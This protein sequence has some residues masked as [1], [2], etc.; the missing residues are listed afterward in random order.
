MNILLIKPFWPYPYNKTDYTY[1]RIWPPLSLANCAG[2][3]EEE[4]FGVKILDCH[5]LRLKPDRIK[6]F[7]S[8][9]D[10][11][12]ITSSSLDRWQ[13]PN[14]NISYFLETLRYIKESTDE[15]YVMGYH[16]TVE[17]KKILDLTDAK[18]VIRG[19]P[20]YTVLEICKNN[21][22]AEIKGLSFK[23]KGRIVSTSG[24][25]PLDLKSL[26]LPAFH[27]LDFRK[28]FYEILGK[29]FSLFEISRGC[30]F[31]CRF[32]NK[33]M[34]GEDLRTKSRGQIFAEVTEAVEKFNVKTGYFI[35]LDFLS[36]REIA[37]ELCNY[38]I[39][40]KY[41]FKW[42]C[43]ARP[44]LLDIE[45]LKKMKSAGCEIIHL[46]IESSVPRLLFYLNKN[47]AIEKVRHSI[48]LCQKAGMKTLAFFLFGLPGETEEDR[49]RIFSC[50]KELNNDFVSFHKIQPYKGSQIYQDKYESEGNNVDRFIRK[51]LIK[52]Y[53]RPSYLYR[54]NLSVILSGFKLLLG[55]IKTLS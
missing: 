34:Y 36:N 29:S 25:E 30:K 10:K 13:C 17:S 55:R 44:D 18:A 41:R 45:I 52:Y 26:P 47:I 54:L 49:N 37:E 5:A 20:E 42:T 35:D 2:I 21:R 11:I 16:G 31:K 50:I 40:K 38:L 43:Q 19:E 28:Y 24:R 27:L 15:I 14:I 48:K 1:N 23:D 33:T 12:F 32:C 51:A 46:G 8:G 4:G 6:G 22:L 3:L 7:L 53:L 39:K 9:F